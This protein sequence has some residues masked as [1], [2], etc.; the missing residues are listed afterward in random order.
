MNIHIDMG[1]IPYNVDVK[2]T[3]TVPLEV[4]KP[5]MNNKNNTN[6]RPDEPGQFYL[7]FAAGRA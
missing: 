2:K 3:F 4:T 6:P 7:S 5:T 1:E